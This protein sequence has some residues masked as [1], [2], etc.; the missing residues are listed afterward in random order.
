MFPDLTRDDVFRLE[1]RRL[2][3]RWPR[4]ADA[5]AILRL[6]GETAVAEMTARIPH[7]YPAEAATAFVLA[8]RRA[9]A[10]GSGLT[11]AITPRAKPGTLIGAVAIT[12]QDGRAALGYWLGSPHW[13]EGLATEAVRAL[14][15]AYFAYTSGGELHASARV[16]NGASRRVIEKCGFVPT[17]SRLH[18]FPA[19]GGVFP[20]DTFRLD[21]RTWSSFKAWSSTGFVPQGRHEESHAV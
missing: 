11:L 14:I 18:P 5:P 10:E 2:W 21:R 7:P 1:T 20:V 4:Q 16:I 19:R 12:E 15:D 17:G 3:L 13:G 9:N 8:S 6:A